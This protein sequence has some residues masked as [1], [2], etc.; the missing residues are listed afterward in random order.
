MQQSNNSRTFGRI[1]TARMYFVIERIGVG[2][3][4][5]AGY[6]M[7]YYLLRSVGKCLVKSG[8]YFLFPLWHVASPMARVKWER[9]EV[10]ERFGP[11]GF[12]AAPSR[13]RQKQN[14]KIESREI[15]NEDRK[16]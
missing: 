16:C 1:G 4:V 3:A 2:F 5:G 12:V 8:S 6:F 9:D 13:T 11:A 7:T 10:P 14:L 15:K